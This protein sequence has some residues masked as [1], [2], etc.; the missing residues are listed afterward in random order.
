MST[1]EGLTPEALVHWRRG[2][3]YTQSQAAGALGVAENTYIAWESGRR[4]ISEPV[5]RLTVY[6]K[7]WGLLL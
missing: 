2:L 4:G 1:R 6:V 5:R 3:N 7:K